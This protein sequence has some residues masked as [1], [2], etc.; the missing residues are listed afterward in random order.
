[1]TKVM[2]FNFETMQY[3]QASE[4]EGKEFIGLI[5]SMNA[6]CAA[7]RRAHPTSG[8]LRGLWSWL[9]L[10]ASSALKHFTSPPTRR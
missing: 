4:T 3:E 5:E 2:V 6:D 7:Q 1:M 9:W 10:R 8:S